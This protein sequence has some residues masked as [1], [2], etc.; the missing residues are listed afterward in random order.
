PITLPSAGAQV[1]TLVAEDDAGNLSVASDP[2]TI[3]LDRA[4]P[5]AVTLDLTP[6]TDAAP[7]G[8]GLTDRQ[9][10]DLAGQTEP[11]ADIFLS[12]AG[13]PL[14]PILRTIAGADGRFRFDGVALASGSNALRVAAADAAGNSVARDLTVGTTAADASGP[15]LA[16]ALVR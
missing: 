4:A 15:A 2:L 8:D 13:G 3:T 6:E 9:R 1:V 10:V 12:R 14:P 7:V 16:A 11:G 5:S